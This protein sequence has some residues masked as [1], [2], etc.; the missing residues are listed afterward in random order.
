MNTRP[1]VIEWSD[2]LKLGIPLVD[3]QHERLVELTNNLYFACLKSPEIANSFFINATNEAIE[4]V[5]YH[6]SSEEKMM[7]FLEYPG[8]S[9]HK[10][11]HHSF[12]MEVLRQSSKLPTGRSLAPNRFVYYLKEWVLS[13]IAVDDKA[14]VNYILSLKNHEKLLNLFPKPA[15]G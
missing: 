12:V 8:Y 1:L 5:Q 9:T 13:H 4:Y 6:F 14:M 10:M 11:Q 3:R 15:N 2:R 7:I